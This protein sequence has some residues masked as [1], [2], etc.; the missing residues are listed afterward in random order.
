MKENEKKGKE[1]GALSRVWELGESE[2]G[3]IAGS[4]VLASIGV[5]L[6][7]LPF[8]MAGLIE[9]EMI[10]GDKRAGYC[11]VCALIGLGGYIAEMRK[12][13]EKSSI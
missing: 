8:I 9:A 10:G 2:H 3:K 5:L 4:A 11:V 13:A 7:I 12:L 6:G 1:K